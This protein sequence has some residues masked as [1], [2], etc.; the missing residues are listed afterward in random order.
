MVTDALEEDGVL[1]D[2]ESREHGAGDGVTDSTSEKAISQNNLS[3]CVL[4]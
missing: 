2:V 4:M 3:E 1:E